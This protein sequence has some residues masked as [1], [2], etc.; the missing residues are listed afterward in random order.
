MT[1]PKRFLFASLLALAYVSGCASPGTPGA[2]A[3]P[4]DVDRAMRAVEQ[5]DRAAAAADD[6]TRA[7]DRAAALAAGHVVDGQPRRAPADVY[8]RQS[9]SFRSKA[10]TTGRLAA[11]QQALADE[12]ADPAEKN[13]WEQ[14]AAESREQ[15]KRLMQLSKQY[16]TL[17]ER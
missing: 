14:R 11:V 15:A 17:A 12:V 13:V 7:A 3:A 16:A 5:A 10:I 6:Q 2:T 4:R 1:D 8:R 9:L